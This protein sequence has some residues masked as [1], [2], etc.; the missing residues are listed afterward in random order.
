MMAGRSTLREKLVKKIINKY[1]GVKTCVANM[2]ITIAS[3]GKVKINKIPV[4]KKKKTVKK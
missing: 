1:S 2:N 3:A 4:Q